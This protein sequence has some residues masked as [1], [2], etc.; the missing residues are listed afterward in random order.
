MRVNYIVLK[1]VFVW[2]LIIAMASCQEDFDAIDTNILNQNITTEFDDSRTVVA[3]SKKLNGVQTNSLPV[4]QLGVYDDPV[5]GK[6]SVNMLTQLSLSQEAISSDISADVV[7][8]SVVVYLPYF[9]NQTT[10]TG[11][12]DTQEQVFTLDSVYGDSPTTIEIF[13]SNFLLRELDP[14][15]GFLEPQEYFSGQ[16][17][18]FENNLGESLAVINDFIPQNKAI[19]LNDSVSQ[20]PGL[21][22]N[23]PVDFFQQRFIANI[24]EPFFDGNNNFRDFFRGLY[25]KS[26]SITNQGNLFLFDL[27]A[28]NP[29]PLANARVILYYTDEDDN[30][31]QELEL[32]FDAVTVNVYENELPSTINNSL[33]NPNISQGE[34]TLYVRGG[35]GIITLIDLFGN[36]Q[37]ENGI[38]DEL[39]D[40]RDRQWLINEAN[41]IFYVDQDRVE[42]GDTEPERLILYD[43]RNNT[44]LADYLLD[45]T[46]ASNFPVDA[47]T[48]H[49]G[50]LDRG[51]DTQGD[52]Y[53]IRITN[54]ISNLINRDSTNTS[55]GLIVSNN[56]T[57]TQFNNLEAAVLPASVSSVPVTSIIS[58]EGTVLHG[59]RSSDLDKRLKLQIFYTE[60]E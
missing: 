45:T 55:L 26:T 13:E 46:A 12:D 23:L 56:V 51:S 40:L 21:R 32:V 30:S 22:V 50:R 41:L 27:S 48:D 37:D 34:E 5:F 59:N 18:V 31:E 29:D 2:C 33:E 1:L 7:L 57:Q 53:K 9:S 4:Y 17:A 60:P 44:V 8:D 28:S 36:D 15:T 19:A 25:F 14:S 35:E 20:P 43:T 42:G 54:H 38:A 49:L 16:G 47:F 3:Y 11:T 58:H 6:S 24:E 10:I 39:E 52:F